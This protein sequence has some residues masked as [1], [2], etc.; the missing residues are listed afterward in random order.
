MLAI[1]PIPAVEIETKKNPIKMVFLAPQA[2]L[3]RALNG[4]KMT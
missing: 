4:A 1:S 2:F 3:I